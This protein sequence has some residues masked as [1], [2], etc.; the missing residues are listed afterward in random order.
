MENKWKTHG[1][2]VENIWKIR[3]YN[4]DSDKWKMNGT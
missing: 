1:K 2:C 4:N 3:G